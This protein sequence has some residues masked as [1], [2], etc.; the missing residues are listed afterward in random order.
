MFAHFCQPWQYHPRE[1]KQG[2]NPEGGEVQ[3]KAQMSKGVELGRGLVLA[4]PH[5]G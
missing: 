3:N 2:R 5:V 4:Q 1:W